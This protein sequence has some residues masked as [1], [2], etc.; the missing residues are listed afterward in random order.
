MHCEFSPSMDGSDL[1][2]PYVSR[3][4][5]KQS[6]R[7]CP[8]RALRIL[9]ND[10]SLP[11]E[12]LLTRTDE[13]KVHIKNLQK[14]MLQIYKCQSEENPSFMWKFFEK[15]DVKYELRTKNLLQTPDLTTN[16][17]GANSLISR[18]AH[19]WNTLPDDIKNVNSSAVFRKKIKEWTGDKC[20]CKICR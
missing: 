6:G 17:I 3:E 15:R 9:H 5:V 13:R 18:G 16:T 4:N 19:L 1:L 20:N 11:F 8:K 14:L 2:I 7:S 10:F 12:V